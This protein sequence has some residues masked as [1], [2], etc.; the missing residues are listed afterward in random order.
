[1]IERPQVQDCLLPYVLYCIGC[2]IGW[3][4]IQHKGHCQ[5]MKHAKLGILFLA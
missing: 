2:G 5:K 4:A 3:Q 1:M